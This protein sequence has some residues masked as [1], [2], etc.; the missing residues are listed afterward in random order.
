MPRECRTNTCQIRSVVLFRLLIL[1]FFVLSL[2]LLPDFSLLLA[3]C[4][5]E[6]QEPPSLPV[7]A[8]EKALDDYYKS[9]LD[10]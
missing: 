5:D 7:Q 8:P 10:R 1:S 4:K 2:A 6:A 9:Y 3:D